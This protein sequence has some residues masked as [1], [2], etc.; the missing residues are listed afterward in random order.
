MKPKYFSWQSV[1]LRDGGLHHIRSGKVVR[2]VRCSWHDGLVVKL[3]LWILLLA[4]NVF[5]VGTRACCYSIMMHARDPL[6]P[7]P[8]LGC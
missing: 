3:D 5:V 4:S 8:C 2:S 1:E 6:A 7:V